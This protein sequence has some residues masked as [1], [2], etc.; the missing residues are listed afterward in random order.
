MNTQA[1]RFAD[2][3][4]GETIRAWP[5]QGCQ[6]SLTEDEVREKVAVTLATGLGLRPGQVS[7]D[8]PIKEGLDVDFFWLA[9]PIMTIENYFR[10][11]L[12]DEF[13]KEDVSIRSIIDKLMGRADSSTGW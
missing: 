8:A 13:A 9:G 2:G 3:H 11:Q 1:T 4:N 5:H 7:D 6:I 12:Q 10:T